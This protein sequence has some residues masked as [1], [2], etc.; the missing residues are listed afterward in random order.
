[1]TDATNTTNTAADTSLENANQI[2]GEE[3]DKEQIVI[4]D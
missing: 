3:K 4:Q 2:N 1:M